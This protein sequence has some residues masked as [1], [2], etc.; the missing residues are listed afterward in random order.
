MTSPGSA[1]R[2][3]RGPVLRSAPWRVFGA[4]VSGAG[5]LRGGLPCQDA[6]RGEYDESTDAL[7]LA[8]ADGAGSRERSAEG[9]AL[10]VG[11]AVDVLRE[12]L[13]AAG[14]PEHGT[15]WLRL[16]AQATDLIHDRFLRVAGQVAAFSHDDAD[17]LATTLTVAVVTLPWVGLI[18]V[19]D[20]FVVARTNEDELHLLLQP[21]HDRDAPNQTTFLTSP[22]S[23]ERAQLT[24]AWE[25]D[26]TG[27]ALATDGLASATLDFDPGR[28]AAPLRPH[29]AYFRPLFDRVAGHEEGWDGIARHL[30]SDGIHATTQD[31]LTILCAVREVAG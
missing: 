17:S 14:R 22:G 8:V 10:A 27:L 18:S 11:V 25:P 13:L 12:T 2:R 5:H 30:L 21:P 19:G 16:L 9:A 7:L 26:L 23:R 28:S 24:Y 29:H 4:S 1:V 15:A 31:D 3:R 6:H 20:G